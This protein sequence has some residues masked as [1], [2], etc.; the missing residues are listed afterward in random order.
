MSSSLKTLLAG[1]LLDSA[2][3]YLT[4]CRSQ[5]SDKIPPMKIALKWTENHSKLKMQAYIILCQIVHWK[6]S[7]DYGYWSQYGAPRELRTRVDIHTRNKPSLA[8]R[9]DHFHVF[10]PFLFTDLFFWGGMLSVDLESKSGCLTEKRKPKPN[11]KTTYLSP[12]QVHIK[13]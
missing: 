10:F 9:L 5:L 8:R 4:K 3:S 12:M 7:W 11:Q 13:Q 6:W 2:S 1:V